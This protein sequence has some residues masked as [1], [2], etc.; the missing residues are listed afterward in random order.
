MKY[1]QIRNVF[2]L[3][4]NCIKLFKTSKIF[5]VTNIR[6]FFFCFEKSKLPDAQMRQEQ[7]KAKFSV[8]RIKLEKF[9]KLL[10]YI[11]SL[12]QSLPLFFNLSLPLSTYLSISLSIN[13]SLFIYFSPLPL[14]L[15]VPPSYLLS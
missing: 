9:A 4:L 6:F 2:L 15:F 13:L 3:Q 10:I 5:E 7:R 1:K 8:L 11:L 12:S 14:S